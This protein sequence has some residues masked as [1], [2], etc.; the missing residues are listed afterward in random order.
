M[1]LEV[2]LA[3][4]VADARELAADLVVST[5]PPR[6]ADALA[7]RAWAPGQSLLDVVYDPWPTALA[8]AVGAAGGAVLSGALMLLHQ[9][10]AQV[11]LMTRRPAPVSAMRAAL[12]AAA[13]GCGV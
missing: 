7:A 13:P 4:L 12:R 3:A 8:G 11:E 9:A 10:A 5:L 1:G 6:G 2:S